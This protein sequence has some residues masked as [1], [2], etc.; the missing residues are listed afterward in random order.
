MRHLLRRSEPAADGVAARRRKHREANRSFSCRQFLWNQAADPYAPEGRASAEMPRGG[1]GI[2]WSAPGETVAIH[3][4]ACAADVRL[5]H[6]ALE[7]KPLGGIASS[8]AA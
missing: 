5:L 7:A 6:D 8:I 1:G 2:P 3:E 4:P